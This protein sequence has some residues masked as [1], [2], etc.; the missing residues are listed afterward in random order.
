MKTL[1]VLALAILGGSCA[2]PRPALQPAETSGFL[3]DYALLR[4]G[5][6]NELQLVYRNPQADWRAYHKVL[7]EP[8]TLWRSGRKSLD[9]VPKDDL[10][11]LV[12]DFQSAVRTRLGEDFDVVDQAGPGVMRIRLGITEAHASDPMLDVLTAAR[13][14]GRAHPAGD[15][16]LDPET[17]RFL[18]AAAI[19]GD[20]RDAQTN[21]LLAEGID[22]RRPGARPFETWAEVDRAF[23]FWA[24]RACT[25][26]EARTGR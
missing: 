22:R 25:R 18:E 12:T 19:E 7:L 2:H 15:G 8:V 23:A 5:G 24:E 1:V 9:P 14:T 10:L 4:P 17:R 3:D 11:R 6:P 26:L 13:G 16:A 21:V 20:I